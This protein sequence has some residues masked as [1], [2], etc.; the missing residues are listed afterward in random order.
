M[1]HRFTNGRLRDGDGVLVDR[2][3][4]HSMSPAG[5]EVVWCTMGSSPLARSGIPASVINAELRMMSPRGSMASR[6]CRAE[7]WC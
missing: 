2:W 1:D 4:R 5:E 7:R 3:E 6:S